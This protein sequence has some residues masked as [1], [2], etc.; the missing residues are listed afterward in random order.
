MAGPANVRWGLSIPSIAYRGSGADRPD[1]IPLP[2]A[3]RPLFRGFRLHKSWRYVGIWSE[4]VSVCA[5]RVRVGPLAQEFWGVWDRSAGQLTEHTRLWAGRVDIRPGGIEVR[6]RGNR[7]DISLDE[8]PKTAFEVVTP[9]GRAWTWVRKLA[10]RAHGIAHVGG[11]EVPIDGMAVIE[12]TDGYHP[13]LTHW[14]WSAGTVVLDDGRVAVWNVIVGLNDTL[15][16]TENTLWIDGRPKQIGLVTFAPDL[17]EVR[18]DDGNSLRF[19]QEAER[20]STVDLF[21]IR[22]AYRQPFGSFTGTLPGGLV[23]DQGFGV[24]EDHRALW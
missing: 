15:P 11:S 10:V 22:S 21:V 12:E 7:L 1:S 4:S 2:P 3:R 17:S 13:R 19:T 16:H 6:D 23:V 8:D 20:A 24:M 18:F 9:T 5:A 14:W